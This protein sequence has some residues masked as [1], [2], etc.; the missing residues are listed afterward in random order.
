[1]NIN[2]DVNALAEQLGQGISAIGQ[3]LGVANES[4]FAYGVKWQ[5]AEGYANL[6]VSVACLVLTNV[7]I[8]V[9]KKCVEK[10]KEDYSYVVGTVL[11]L[12]L[13]LIAIGFTIKGLY[14][15]V[16][17]LYAPEAMLVP[18]AVKQAKMLMQ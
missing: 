14:Y 1:M 11:S 6:A 17:H 13:A 8:W 10:S 3:K 16:M 7:L 2:F 5:V 15:G 12:I 9:A 4:V 18:E